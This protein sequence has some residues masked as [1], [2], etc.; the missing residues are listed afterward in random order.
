M[1]EIKSVEMIRKIRDAQYAATK[2]MS[3][4]K[5]KAYF[6]SEARLAEEE[7]ERINVAM[8]GAT[9]VVPNECIKADR[10]KPAVS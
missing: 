5:L 7:A 3:P 9:V 10:E 4:E 2:M 6:Q 1:E 8:C